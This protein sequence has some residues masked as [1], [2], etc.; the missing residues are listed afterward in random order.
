MTPEIKAGPAARKAARELNAPLRHIYGSG[1]GGRITKTDVENAVKPAG[2][3]KNSPLVWQVARRGKAF[4]NSLP[5]K[6][7][8]YQT[9]EVRH[10]AAPSRILCWTMRAGKTVTSVANAYA[11]DAKAV[12]LVVRNGT[13]A[14]LESQ[15]KRFGRKRFAVLTFDRQLHGEQNGKP[16]RPAEFNRMMD[17]VS[18]RRPNQWEGRCKVFIVHYE[19]LTSASREFIDT[20]VRSHP[21][22]SAGLMVVDESHRMKSPKAK[23]TDAATELLTQFCWRRM[24]SGTAFTERPTDFFTQLR[25]LAAK[26]RRAAQDISEETAK[27][28]GGRAGETGKARRVVNWVTDPSILPPQWSTAAAFRSFFYPARSMPIDADGK[29]CD[30]ENAPKRMTAYGMK[31]RFAMWSEPQYPEE[32]AA[33]VSDNGTVVDKDDLAGFPDLRKIIVPAQ[34]SAEALFAYKEM[35]RTGEMMVKRGDG[36]FALK[37]HIGRMMTVVS[38]GFI[39][40]TVKDPNGKEHRIPR[41]FADDGKDNRP[42]KMDLLLAKLEEI[43]VDSEAAMKRAKAGKKK[44]PASAR[45]VV[46]VSWKAEQELVARLLEKAGYNVAQLRSEDNVTKREAQIEMFRSGEA[47]ILVA[48]PEIGGEGIDLSCADYAIRVSRKYGAV[49]KT[50]SDARIVKAGKNQAIFIDIIS[51]NT[52]D[53]IVHQ[54]DA[55]KVGVSNALAKEARGDSQRRLLEESVKMFRQAFLETP[56][57][58]MEDEEITETETEENWQEAA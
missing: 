24:M 2:R 32:F 26:A 34:P 37:N 38:A 27:V 19:A 46:W 39:Y 11:L 30:R 10:F 42:H 14:E 18:N 5:F 6:A 13:Q 17:F 47:S 50:Q 23:V 36:E 49:V 54:R 21:C 56:R 1:R 48:M 4:F 16:R 7:F 41:W 3:S 44:M 29:P 20:F 55:A 12:L 31:P 40:D 58:R 35:L 43:F 52:I 51:E 22:K 57:Q 28:C 53:A 15:Y 9:G 8:Q 25:G 45:V 33:L